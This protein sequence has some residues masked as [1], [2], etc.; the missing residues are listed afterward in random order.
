MDGSGIIHH[1]T[2]KSSFFMLL[3]ACRL[4]KRILALVIGLWASVSFVA[5]GSYNGS[6]SGSSNGTTDRVL[7]AQG[8]QTSV[9]FGALVAIDGKNDTLPRTAP[10]ATGSFNLMA[11]SP[12]RNI[13]AAFDAS[14][15]AVNAVSTATEKSIGS[16]HIQGPTISLI[17][18][19]DS[20]LAY[21]AVP[22]ATVSGFSFV[23]ALDVVNFANGGLTAIAVP[24]AQTVV[25]NKTGT[26]L[27]VFSS[28][29]DAITVLSPAAANPPVDTSCLAPNLNPAVCT[30]VQDSRLS[31]PVNAIISG[32]TAYV[33]NCG[34]EC[35]GT[36]QA[37]V[38]LLDLGSLTVTSTIPVNGATDALLN[39]STLYVAGKGTP[40]GPLCSTLTNSINPP[41]AAI[42]CGTLDILNLNTMTDPYFN[43]PA[44]EIAIPDGYYQ[45][46]DLTQDGQL[47]VG[48]RDCTNIGNV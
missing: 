29:S 5:C 19:T 35:G 17:V 41:T 20:A 44:T 21:A 43:S 6:N 46:M 11:I 30:F 9:T 3:G 47:F 38:A 2:I 40:T 39:G 15:N 7:A 42:F 24:S 28:D 36:Q 10:V 1:F 22:S 25:S 27:L 4:K 48:A 34:F 45:R 12:S 14:S 32:N 37:S 13:V 31:R 8:V 26:Q 16:I 18:P 23:G 33:L